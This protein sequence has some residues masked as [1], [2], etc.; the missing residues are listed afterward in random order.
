MDFLIA[1]WWTNFYGRVK[2]KT[3][4]IGINSFLAERSAIKNVK[5]TQCLIGRWQ[6][7]SKTERLLRCLLTKTTW[8]LKM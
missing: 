8:S 7:D 3:I 1:N 6:L 4:K 2:P 5:L